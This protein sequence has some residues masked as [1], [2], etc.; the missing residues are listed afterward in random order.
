MRYIFVALMNK[1]H[2]DVNDKKRSE[3]SDLFFF[4]ANS[5]YSFW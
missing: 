1:R 3:S 5:V 2:K 4:C